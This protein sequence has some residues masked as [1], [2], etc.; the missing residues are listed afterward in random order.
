MRGAQLASEVSQSLN[1]GSATTST[2]S[3]TPVSPV[4]PTIECAAV[5][6]E[7]GHCSA[8]NAPRKPGTSCGIHLD[9]YPTCLRHYGV[10]E[11]VKMIAAKCGGEKKAG[12]LRARLRLEINRTT[13]IR[14]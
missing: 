9:E 5:I 1:D 3:S 12:H 14:G 10:E 7:C 4:A 6:A 13:I 11:R 8:A 2:R